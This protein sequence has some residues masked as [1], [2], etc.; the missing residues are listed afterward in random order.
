MR[1]T[2]YAKK[3]LEEIGMIECNATQSPMDAGLKLSKGQE[4]ESVNEREYRKTIGCLRYLIHTQPDLAY[5]V[6]VLS[7]YMHEPK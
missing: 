2:S 1:Q 5:S 4:E 7:R 3:I 6:G